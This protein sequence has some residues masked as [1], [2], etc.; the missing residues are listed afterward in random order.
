MN[1]P[2]LSHPS[3]TLGGFREAAAGVKHAA[4]RAHMHRHAQRGQ[5]AAERDSRWRSYHD[6]LERLR[7]RLGSLMSDLMRWQPP[8]PPGASPSS[9]PLEPCPRGASA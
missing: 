2:T 4:F 8:P 1:N 6:E 9:V 5:P 7:S 3:D